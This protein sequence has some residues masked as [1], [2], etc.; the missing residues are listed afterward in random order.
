MHSILVMKW[1]NIM[2]LKNG[3]ELV[4]DKAKKS[5]AALTIEYM[6]K[7]GG[8]STE[9]VFEEN[10][11]KVPVHA[12]EMFIESLTHNKTS[13]MFVGKID[14]EIVSIGNVTTQSRSRMLHVAEYAITVRKKY[15]DLNIG[16]H[17][18]EEM[19]KFSKA[20]GKTEM[21]YLYVKADNS[22][23]IHLY[24]KFGF[25]ECGVLENFFKIAGKRY[26]RLTM[27]LKL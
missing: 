19:I 10:E 16:T 26:D 8:E 7:V 4:I 17:M 5:D 2:I 24:K 21:I 1:E 27:S 23:A 14:G 20:S 6:N 15:W 18:M 13:A 3:M 12:E 25:V 11:F 22:K 9:L